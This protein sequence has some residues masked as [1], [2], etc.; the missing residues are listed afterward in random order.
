VD[1]T[2]PQFA[3]AVAFD[4]VN[5]ACMRSTFALLGLVACACSTDGDVLTRLPPREPWVPRAADDFV[6]SIGLTVPRAGDAR[7]DTV[8]LPALATLGV[9]HIR[10]WALVPEESAA[11][12]TTLQ[13]LAAMGIRSHLIFEPRFG[14]EPE[15]FAQLAAQLGDALESVEGPNDND[16]NDV[17]LGTEQV[18]AYLRALRDAID[19]AQLTERVALVD[20]LDIDPVEKGNLAEVLDYGNF[21]RDRDRGLPALDLSEQKSAAR[22][23]CGG[24]PL[25]V[26]ECGYSTADSDTGVSEATAAKYVLRLLLGHFEQNIARTYVDEL[27]DGPED[28]SVDFMSQGLLHIDGS[29]KPAFGALQRLIALLTDEGP[30]FELSPLD[31]ALDDVSADL[32]S[33]L[34]QKRDGAHALVL[35]QE[36]PSFDLV[37]L[38]PAP[39]S[40]VIELATPAARVAV[41]EPAHGAEPVMELD[42]TL[43]V[44]VEV[45]D[46][47]AVVLI[48]P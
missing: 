20:A 9:R 24:K 22:L 38:D 18:V 29:E 31:V 10:D 12:A 41:Y 15:H 26:T 2:A 14:V 32:R 42:G 11:Q 25:M 21:E 28:D 46:H 48:E 30:P 45:R 6:D 4:C 37:D 8:A 17:D 43:E 19:E 13:A 47:P 39:R 35:W 1:A 34:L 44:E 40:V 16:A 36:V 5:R 3:L 23:V 33:L 27:A 7:F